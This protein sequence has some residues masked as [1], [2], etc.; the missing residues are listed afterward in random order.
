MGTKR[1]RWGSQLLSS[2]APQRHN[3]YPTYKINTGPRRKRWKTR[4]NQ[5]RKQKSSRI[6]RWE[7]TTTDQPPA[8]RPSTWRQRCGMGA[9][10]PPQPAGIRDRRKVV[11]RLRAICTATRVHPLGEIRSLKPAGSTLANTGKSRLQDAGAAQR[12]DQS[13]KGQSWGPD[14]QPGPL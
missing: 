7:R 9:R 11:A 12:T 1:E 14:P 8:L 6:R 4:K 2:P 13:R 10:G 5:E 3:F